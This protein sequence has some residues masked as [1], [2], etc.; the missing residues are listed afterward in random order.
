MIAGGG[1][2]TQGT[3]AGLVGGANDRLGSVA[4]GS[5]PTT[6]TDAIE[7]DA[8]LSSVDN[9]WTQFEEF[10]EF[11]DGVETVEQLDDT[12]LRWVA[13]V[14][15]KRAEWEAKTLHQDPEW[16]IA[17]PSTDG[18]Q[19]TGTVTFESLGGERTRIQLAM[20]YAPEGPVERAGSAIGPRQPPGPRRPPAVQGADRAPRR[21]ERRL[22][23]GDQG[24]EEGPPPPKPSEAIGVAFRR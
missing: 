10:P 9:Q 1:D 18:K 7:I 24:R 14:A 3:C 13:K 19:A 22:A 12:R 2:S 21:R 5:S 15:G 6:I 11:M 17:W 16:R 23:R 20:T 4:A 8:P